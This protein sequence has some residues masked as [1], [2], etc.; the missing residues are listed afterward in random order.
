[1]GIST[2]LNSG[3]QAGIQNAAVVNGLASGA[4]PMDYAI[5]SVFVMGLTPPEVSQV[6]GVSVVQ[7]LNFTLIAYVIVVLTAL[8]ITAYFLWGKKAEV[9]NENI[10]K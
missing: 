8:A 6:A 4:N 1:M 9:I 5:P 7:T 3:L 10:P 2:L